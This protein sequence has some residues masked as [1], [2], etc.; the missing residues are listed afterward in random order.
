MLIVNIIA[1]LSALIVLVGTGAIIWD[2]RNTDVKDAFNSD[3]WVSYLTL[4]VLFFGS[5]LGVA[6]QLVEWLV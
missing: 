2:E 5:A 6:G 4:L 1:F 3:N